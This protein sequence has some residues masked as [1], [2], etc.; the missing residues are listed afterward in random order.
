[1]KP[2]RGLSAEEAAAWARLAATVRPLR[3]IPPRHGEGDQPQA[4]GE[5]SPPKP[6]P[7]TKRPAANP[8]RQPS[9]LPPPR[10]GEDRGGLDSTWDRKLT[11]GTLAPDFTLD[12][13]GHT[14]SSAH[15]RLDD[16]LN[17]LPAR[18]TALTYAL[19]GRTRSA[20]NCWRTQAPGWDS[21]NAG[22]VMAAG[23][24]SLGVL[25]GG[26]AIYHG[27]EE[28]RPPL[29]DGP[30]P[31]AADLGRAI[32]LI[33]RSVLLWLAVFLMIGFLHA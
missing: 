16:G 15:A 20:L 3:N 5:G 26:A 2:P 31:M 28:I 32:T 22:P 29:G 14:L 23:A 10:P 4:G 33:R 13:H 9:G 17:W 19:L 25:L 8:L 18:L 1:M 12:L 11:R 6:S 24:G 7:A 30:P 21:P 27:H